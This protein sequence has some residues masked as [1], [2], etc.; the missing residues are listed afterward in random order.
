M[1]TWTFLGVGAAFA[2]RNFQSNVLVE[3]WRKGPDYQERPDDTLLID[4]G[5]IA[6]LALNELRHKKGFGYLSNDRRIYYPAI[7]K[8]FITHQHADHIGGLEELAL[9]NMFTFGDPDTGKPYKPQLISSINV[10][11][12]LWDNSLKGGLNTVPGKYALLQDYF[13]ILSLVPEQQGRESFNMIKRYRFKLFATDH[14][15]ITRKYDWPSHGLF[16]EDTQTGKAVFFSGD[17]R[18]D[19]AAYAEMMHRAQTC[20]HDVQLIEQKD[21]VHSLLSDLR[22]MPAEIKKKTCLYHYG[23]NWDE[24]PFDFVEDEFA[25][26]VRQQE[27]MV[28][29]E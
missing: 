1:L 8:I 24:G 12:N 15:Q 4:F 17:T 21:P 3:A 14:V 9:M 18:F 10:L 25:G 27:R 29:F 20:F 28:L 11:M 16:V 22:T 13:F 26:F 5:S 7:R 19:Y 2:K 6:P 23:D